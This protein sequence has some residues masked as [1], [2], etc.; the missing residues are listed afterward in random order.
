MA[1]D[2]FESQH[3]ARRNTGRLVVLFGLAVVAIIVVV[4]L[5]VSTF[6]LWSRAQRT[7]DAQLGASDFFDPVLL[8]TVG[9][10]TIAVVG[11]ASLYK[12]GELR[13]GGAVI[14]ESLGG[15]L[16]RPGSVD[17][18][19]R[20]LLNVVEEM[21]I[22]SGTPVP[23]VYLLDDESGINA[24]AAGHSPSDAVI[25]VTRGSVEHLSRDE[26][27]GVIAH[28]FSHILNGDMRLNIR[29][30]GVLF[31]ILVIG[32]IG[33]ILIRAAIYTPRTSS[34]RG[35]SP[36]A[37]V[38]LALALI[39][40][41]YVG[42]FF[43]KLIKAGV[44]RQRE[45]L[46]DASA[47][48]FTRN[49]SGIAGALKKI[50]GL[51]IGS[52]LEHPRAEEASHMYFGQG[53]KSMLSMMATH[54]PLPD[55]IKRIEPGWDGTFPKVTRTTK[56][57]KRRGRKSADRRRA[58]LEA[59]AGIGAGMAQAALAERA[60]T[61]VGQVGRPT[62][63]H[64]DY[65]SRLIARLPDDVKD[66]AREPYGARA[67]IYAL[68]LNDESAPREKQLARLAEHADEG[69]HRLTLKL[70][71]T[72]AHCEMDARLP[73]LDMCIGSLVGL[74]P[75]Q[76]RMFQQNVSEL[77]RADEKLDLFEWVLGRILVRHLDPH[78]REIRA[79]IVQYYNLNALHGEC[80][81][82]L[83]TLAHVGHRV[84]DDTERAFAAGAS[85]LAIGA[86]E[87]LPI[88]QCSLGDL[89]G[90]LD[91]LA[92][93]T[94]RYKRTV[95]EACA[96]CI[97]ADREVTVREAELLRAVADT[98]DCPMPPLLPGQPLV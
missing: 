1:M 9:I 5:V 87:L 62:P 33:S 4:Y 56:P 73:L 97:S 38:A 84:R 15:R 89:D 61:A 20:K 6:V 37:L 50:G 94:P 40:I 27:Q 54:P 75:D 43:G 7:M 47:V 90:V 21:A 58:G 51:S 79:P 68:L 22:A 67:V 95:L 98:L 25:G 52:R 83:S 41:G 53:I 36:A 49:P 92:Q 30:I 23:P 80:A 71:P 66:A 72:V 64:L 78:F 77:I 28:E 44:S 13:G 8:V 35:G 3:T 91:R 16:L 88:D 93:V 74:T 96:T 2:F 70:A 46:A 14:A 82:L 81:T 24:F 85:R 11:L 34:R 65:A 76:Y 32:F 10:G 86:L 48:Q 29:L 42:T 57:P 26:L 55:R 45:Y 59:V 63:A 18:D 69:V 39:V 12:L 60:S 19:E 17:P 31:G